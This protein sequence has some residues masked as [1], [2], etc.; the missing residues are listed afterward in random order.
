MRIFSLILICFICTL[1]AADL[2][3]LSDDLKPLVQ[4]L[5][6]GSDKERK[7][8]AK[9][10]GKLKEKAKA[11]VPFLTQAM[12]KEENVYVK[13]VIRSALKRIGPA[14]ASAAKEEKEDNGKVAVGG[15]AKDADGYKIPLPSPQKNKLRVFF[16]AD[17]IGEIG[18]TAAKT[19]VLT[20]EIPG[21]KNNNKYTLI[22][23]TGD[24]WSGK[25]INWANFWDQSPLKIYPN[26]NTHIVIRC[27]YLGRPGDINVSVAAQT[28]DG[29]QSDFLRLSNYDSKRLLQK[30]K[31]FVDIAIPIKD[32]HNSI[33]EE[34][35]KKPIWGLHFGYMSHKAEKDM[36]LLIKHIAAGKLK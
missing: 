28:Q 5:L 6:E 21:L 8:A 16:S 9:D 36:G 34:D 27:L 22:H 35:R 33:P 14:D 29:E 4:N 31:H 3:S 15:G 25:I 32:F 7:A 19:K 10:L 26:Q 17:G 18:G 11:A 2:D 24:D 23:L 30:S 12:E 13:K 1:Q 20:K